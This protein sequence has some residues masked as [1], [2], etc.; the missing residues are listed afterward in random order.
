MNFFSE[1]KVNILSEMPR[2]TG[3]CSSVESTPSVVTLEHHPSLR[4]ASESNENLEIKV[5]CKVIIHDVL[6]EEVFRVLVEKHGNDFFTDHEQ[7]H[8]VDSK[9]S[10]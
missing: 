4:D 1:A 5:L 3:T 6:I 10:N 9:N 8:N 2:L 7:I